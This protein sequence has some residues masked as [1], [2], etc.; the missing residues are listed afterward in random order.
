MDTSLVGPNRS[1]MFRHGHWRQLKSVLQESRPN[2]E[3]ALAYVALDKFRY[4]DGS[5]YYRPIRYL[6]LRGSDLEHQSRSRITISSQGMARLLTWM[7]QLNHDPSQLR[8]LLEIHTHP[9]QVGAFFSSL[10]EQ[11]DWN[12]VRGGARQAIGNPDY[13]TMVLNYEMDQYCARMWEGDTGPLP[14]TVSLW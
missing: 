2:D 9:P 10:D 14:V 8:H 7:Y 5:A 13:L 11:S 1:V 12:W 4:D 6:A 3:E